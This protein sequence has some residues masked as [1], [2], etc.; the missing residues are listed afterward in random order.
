MAA[1][2]VSISSCS[3]EGKVP[4][5]IGVGGG[6]ASGKVISFSAVVCH[7]VVVFNL[8]FL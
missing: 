1:K 8:T 7:Y 5:L 3:V 6:T 2:R 4:F